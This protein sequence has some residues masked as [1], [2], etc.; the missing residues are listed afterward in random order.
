MFKN[1][2]RS[3]KYILF[4]LL[5]DI[6]FFHSCFMSYKSNFFEDKKLNIYCLES[7]LK[8]DTACE[9]SNRIDSSAHIDSKFMINGSS[10]T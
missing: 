3:A 10:E 4:S 2:K 7:F 8:E 5:F 9:Y 6:L 1:N